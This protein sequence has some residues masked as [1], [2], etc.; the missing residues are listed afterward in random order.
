[1]KRLFSLIFPAWLT[2][3]FLGALPFY[4]SGFFPSFT[5]AFFESVSGFTTT[6]ATLVSNLEAL[7]GWLLLWRSM[8]QW[9]GGAGILLT[10]I[11]LPVFSPGG[12]QLEKV[13]T[14]GLNG[15][16]FDRGFRHTAGVVL[17]IYAAL[18]ALQFLLLVIFGMDKFDALTTS[19]ST[20][21]TGGF[22][23]RNNSIAYYNSP[24]AEWV[25]A[26]FMFLAGTNLAL[27][28]LLLRGKTAGVMRNSE[29]RAYA[30]VS[31]FAAVFITVL[32]L[33][34][35]PSFKNIGTTLRQAFFQVTSIISTTGFY[36]VDYNIWPSAAQG[37]LF[38]LLFTGGCSFSAAGGIKIVRCLLLSKQTWKEMK[39]LVHHRGVFIIRLN[40]REWNKRA[41]HGAAGFVILYFVT[42]FFAGL[43]VGSSGAGVFT[44]MNTALVCLGNIGRGLGELGAFMPFPEFPSYVKWGLSFVMILGRLELWIV[45]IIFTGDFWRR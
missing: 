43:L 20:M 44:S 38:F 41:V 6:G 1:M 34:Q 22:S 42:A 25:C 15:K 26:V 8:T 5:D 28:W 32:I 39:R 17:L 3:C 21:S 24:A 36:S 33:A 4:F 35:S 7:P 18:T 27:I 45:L 10:F 11:M 12:F 16:G 37:V 40:G 29:A 30:A 31:A 14:A 9:L 19:F 2:V 23:V 13:D